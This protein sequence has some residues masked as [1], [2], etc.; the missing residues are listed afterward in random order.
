MHYDVNEVR[1]DL[2]SEVEAKKQVGCISL[3]LMATM[4]LYNRRILSPDI[5]NRAYK[6]LDFTADPIY[7]FMNT[8]YHSEMVREL[9][10]SF[11]NG[12]IRM[13]YFDADRLCRETRNIQNFHNFSREVVSLYK[14]IELAEMMS[15]QK[16]EWALN[17]ID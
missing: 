12:C 15:Q 3:I 11:K 8:Y 6:E 14:A 7:T 16:L 13:D 17:G 10:D 4:D 9:R 5:L 2:A 1:L